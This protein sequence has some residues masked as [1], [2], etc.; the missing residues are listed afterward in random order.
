MELQL[1]WDHGDDELTVGGLP[2]GTPGDEASVVLLGKIKLDEAVGS[3]H[4]E[5][6]TSGDMLCT[7]AGRNYLIAPALVKHTDD[8][9]TDDTF[10]FI[11]MATS[12]APKS[13]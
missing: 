9:R 11:G 2:L 13:S 10:M 8:G 7:V 6:T 12:A 4:F 3:D 1:V 5:V